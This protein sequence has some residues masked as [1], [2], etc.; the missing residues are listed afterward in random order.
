MRGRVERR[1]ERERRLIRWKVYTSGG[2]S[3]SQLHLQE[4][5]DGE[6]PHNPFRPSF[7]TSDADSVRDEEADEDPRLE[8]VRYTIW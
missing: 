1:G 4:F 3:T 7:R 5:H 2:S 8:N 6:P